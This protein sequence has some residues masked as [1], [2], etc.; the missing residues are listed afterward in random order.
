MSEYHVHPSENPFL[1]NPLALFL[2]LFLDLV[3]M[4]RPAT[5]PTC[6]AWSLLTVGSLC[7]AYFLSNTILLWVPTH[8]GHTGRNLTGRLPEGFKLDSNGVNF[9][10]AAVWT[11]FASDVD[12]EDEA[13]DYSGSRASQITCTM[14]T[15]FD[16]S[17][18]KG[19]FKVY[20]YPS[21]DGSLVSPTYGKMLNVLYHSDFLTRNPAKACLF[22]PSLDTLDRDPLSPRFGH[23]VAQQLVSLPFWN[24]LPEMHTEEQLMSNLD[25]N[26]KSKHQPGRNHL[27]FNLYAGTWPNY[28]EDEYRL[29]LGQAMLAKASFSTTRI[30]RNFDISLPLIHPQ[31]SETIRES[32]STDFSA[33]LRSQVRKP[34]LLSFKGKRYVSGIGSASRNALF[35]LHNGDDII[36]LTTCRHGSDWARYADRRCAFDMA[37]YDKYDYNELMNNST[38]CLVSRGRRLGSYRFLEALQASCIPVM[39]SNDWELPFSEVIDWRRAV[40]WGDERLPLI[41]PL[42]LRRLTDH[43]IVQLRQQVAFLW[44]TYFRS[45]QSIVLTTLEIIRDR[46]ALHRRSYAIWNSPP[47]GLVFSQR[48]S[49]QVCHVPLEQLTG[50]CAAELKEGFTIII[51]VRQHMCSS[52]KSLLGRLVS[53]IFQSRFIRKLL[54]V[55]LC[56]DLPPS[57]DTFQPHIPVPV[58][59][60]IPDEFRDLLSGASSDPSPAVRFQPFFNVPTLAVFAFTMELELTREEVEFGYRVW[61]EFPGRLV[62]YQSASHRRNTS[63][64]LWEYVPDPV[65]RN[66]SIV[67]LKAA[68]YHRHYNYLYWS[69]V[70]SKLHEIVG[71]LNDCEDLLLNAL[72]AHVSQAPPILVRAA[73]AKNLPAD[74][75]PKEHAIQRSACL[76]AFSESFSA[77]SSVFWSLRRS[78]NM[79]PMNQEQ[80]VG[81]NA[82]TYLPLNYASY[83]FQPT[84]SE[85]GS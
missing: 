48:H 69:T 5:H 50:H 22:I 35:H 12:S 17:R 38:F 81:A 41:L 73:A 54:V 57:A 51:P 83:S 36:M 20:V 16:F 52:F 55:W 67:L 40:V 68:F 10:D 72:V 60:V 15:C 47:G 6:Q 71:V 70:E 77:T 32:A 33:R 25:L 49:A 2:P 8:D 11:A 66:Y 75:H 21:S 1:H 78:T 42:A 80:I 29:S 34:I 53:T 85:G 31:H 46:I 24:Q 19:D 14:E 74:T 64:G 28:H 39:L 76:Q 82:N 3:H 23:R 59:V 79:T 63:N 30:R 84:T 4:S 43:Q 62:G 26:R 37:L 61:Q 9:L 58:E 65:D 45:V 27:I 13:P 18:C 44:N 56:P 7:L